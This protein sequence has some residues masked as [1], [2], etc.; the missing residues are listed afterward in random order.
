M[1]NPELH[2]WLDQVMKATDEGTIK[3][4]MANPTTYTWEIPAPKNG[5]VIL[6]RVDRM[7]T[8]QVAP[9]RVAQR[10]IVQYILQVFD[11]QKLQVPAI[12]LSGAEDPEA[13]TQLEKLFGVASSAATR[14]SLNFLK[15]LLPGEPG[16][17]GPHT[18]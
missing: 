6:Q 13:N 16:T 9:G 7:E 8:Y 2:D 5:R 12:Q 1:P 3:W 17:G 11:L 14:D 4:R 15:S 10:K 18:K